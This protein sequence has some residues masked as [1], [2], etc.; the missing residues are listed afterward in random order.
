LK[1]LYPRFSPSRTFIR[2]SLILLSVSN[3][4]IR[5]RNSAVFSSTPIPV[6]GSM[7]CPMK[8]LAP[9]IFPVSTVQIS[10]DWAVALL[11]G[12]YGAFSGSY[13]VIP[14]GASTFSIRVFCR[15]A[16][17]C[18]SPEGVDVRDIGQ[19]AAFVSS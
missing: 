8:Y 3:I 11:S 18:L 2:V 16:I 14:T 10:S 4:I 15:L 6:D 19:Y 7:L 9:I 1:L 5:F 12:E 13:P 17:M